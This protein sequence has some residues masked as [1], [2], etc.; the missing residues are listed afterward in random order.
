MEER[1]RERESERALDVLFLH[2]TGTGRSPGC[3]LLMLSAFTSLVSMA[4][5]CLP[6]RLAG[7]TGPSHIR[8]PEDI[9]E[10]IRRAYKV[11]R[12]MMSPV[13]YTGFPE[14]SSPFSD[15]PRRS[16]IPVCYIAIPVSI[17]PCSHSEKIDNVLELVQQDGID[18]SP[19]LLSRRGFCLHTS[20]ILFWG[21]QLGDDR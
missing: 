11:Y 19:A 15:I 12:R 4:L 16:S 5:F 17:P 10:S 7:T 14:P 9:I 20:E 18:I 2:S 21:C 6:P 3:G 8:G 13:E 1:R